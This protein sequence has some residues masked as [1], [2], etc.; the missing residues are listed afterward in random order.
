MYYAVVWQHATARYGVCAQHVRSRYG[1]CEQYTHHT[2][3]N[4]L[5]HH[6]IIHNNV[7]LPIALT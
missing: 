6:R 3:H 1:V 5:P 7:I 2:G 4:V